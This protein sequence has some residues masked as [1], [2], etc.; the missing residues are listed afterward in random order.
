MWCSRDACRAH[1]AVC[2]VGTAAGWQRGGGSELGR[3]IKVRGRAHHLLAGWECLCV[4]ILRGDVLRTAA[5]RAGWLRERGKL[6][7][8]GHRDVRR[9]RVHDA[10]RPASLHA[11]PQ[12]VILLGRLERVW[13]PSLEQ[14]ETVRTRT[15]VVHG[16]CYRRTHGII[17]TL[18]PAG[19]VKL[20]RVF[21]PPPRL[22]HTARGIRVRQTTL[23]QRTCSALC[24][25]TPAHTPLPVG[26]SMRGWSSFLR[27]LL[28]LTVL[29]ATEAQPRR[30]RMGTAAARVP[31]T[32]TKPHL[33]VFSSSTLRLEPPVPVD[34]IL[35]VALRALPYTQSPL[36]V[37]VTPAG[38]RRS[39][40]PLK[41][42]LRSP[43]RFR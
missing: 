9:W 33:Q 14:V 39:P 34:S 32:S 11:P 22:F 36:P 41:L 20:L 30:A 19:L 2:V 40:L 28:L 21:W 38:V 16:G 5:R 37:L 23:S 35:H 29:A 25:P 1:P 10:P 17:T 7:V 15:V 12:V 26:N 42:K 27:L 18:R 13:T 3:H 6:G 43:R 8:M 24:P 31:V 4:V